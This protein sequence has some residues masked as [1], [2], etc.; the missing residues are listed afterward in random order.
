MHLEVFREGIPVIS[1][2]LF[3]SSDGIVVPEEATFLHNHLFIEPY[4]KKRAQLAKLSFLLKCKYYTFS[5]STD[6]M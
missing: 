1:D 4:I 3:S 6:Q 5:S 2:F